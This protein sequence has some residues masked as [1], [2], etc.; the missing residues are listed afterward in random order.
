MVKPQFICL[1]SGCVWG[2]ELTAIQLDSKLNTIKVSHNTK[3]L[4]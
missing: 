4:I 3:N 1:D 2:R